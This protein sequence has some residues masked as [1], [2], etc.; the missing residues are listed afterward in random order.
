MY[1]MA[2]DAMNAKQ[3]IEPTFCA[4]TTVISTETNINK[5]LCTAHRRGIMV[6]VV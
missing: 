5:I 4:E 2:C 6:H 3:I 1:K